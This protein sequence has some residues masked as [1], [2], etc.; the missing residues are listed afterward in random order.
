MKNLIRISLALFLGASL[1]SATALGVAHAQE[2]AANAPMLLPVD[3]TP[4]TIERDGEAIAAFDIEIAD[5]SSERSRGL[6]FRTEFPD[7]RAMLFVFEK[8]RPVA[9]WMQNTPRPLDML[10]IRADGEVESIALDT[11][12]FSTASVPSQGSVLYVLEINA[13]LT[14]KLGLQPGDRVVHPIISGGAG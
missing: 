12:P 4:L 1:V 3:E 10:F 13:G 9:F 2:A 14:E 5:D 11:T 6:M 8:S 7:D